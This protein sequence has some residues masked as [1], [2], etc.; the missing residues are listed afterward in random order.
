MRA[1]WESPFR[2]HGGVT[3]AEPLAYLPDLNV[4]VQ[5]PIRRSRRFRS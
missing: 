5:G 4:L 1:L 3:L 2:E